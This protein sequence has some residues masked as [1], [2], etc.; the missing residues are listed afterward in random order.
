[1]AARILVVATAVAV[2]A[3]SGVEVAGDGG[4]EGSGSLG[5]LV[6][7][8]VEGT[9]IEFSRLVGSRPLVISFWATYCKPCKSEMPFLQQMHEKYGERGLEVIAVSLD[10]PE[11]ESMVLPFIQKNRYTFKVAIDRQSEAT[12]LLNPKSVLP[13]V[14]VVDRQGRVVKQKDGFSV[15][16]QPHLEALFA[17]LVEQ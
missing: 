4:G 6:L 5:T 9:P 10:T 8:D 13:F 11:S 1:M 2:L 15:G 3:C 17:G 12:M 16:D 14:V 7:T